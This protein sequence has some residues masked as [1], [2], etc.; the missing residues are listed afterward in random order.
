MQDDNTKTHRV[1]KRPSYESQKIS[2]ALSEE[3][4]TAGIALETFLLLRPSERMKR[5]SD[6]MKKLGMQDSEMSDE[7]RYRDYWRR[8]KSE[9]EDMADASEEP[10]RE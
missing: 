5:L 10:C 4:S 3:C 9:R 8:L 6:R 1:G 2:R 7:R